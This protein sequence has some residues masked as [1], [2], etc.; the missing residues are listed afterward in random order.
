MTLQRRDIVEKA[1]LKY[2]GMLHKYLVYKY[3]K[4]ANLKLVEGL[5]MMA[6]AR[7]ADEIVQRRLPV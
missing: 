4:K 5:M 6:Y 2:L 1:Q 7:E 3:G